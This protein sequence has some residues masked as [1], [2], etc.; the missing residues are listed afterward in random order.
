MGDLKWFRMHCDA[1]DNVKLRMLAF[2]DRWHYVAI[3]CL[4][5][6]GLLEKSDDKNYLRMVSIKLGLDVMALEEVKRRLIEVDLVDDNLQPLGWDKH[7]YKTDSSVERVRK[8]RAAKDVTNKKRYSNV[9]VTPPETEAET[10]A[11]TKDK[12][13]VA[14]RPVSDFNDDV[15]RLGI[16]LELWEEFLKNRKRLRA[17]NTPAALKTLINK[18]ERFQQQGH[19][20]NALV[21]TANERGWKSVFEPDQPKSG[22]SPTAREIAGMSF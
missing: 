16:N 8:H 3:C 2:E 7:Q 20:A 15:I 5:G 21:E 22:N 13:K 11:E 10:E 17:S 9:T 18:I 12:K 19:D 4:K 14:T 1:I 6:E